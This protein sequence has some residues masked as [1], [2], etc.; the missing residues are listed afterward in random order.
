MP[1]QA[2]PGL[3]RIDF[4]TLIGIVLGAISLLVSVLAIVLFQEAR[5]TIGNEARAYGHEILLWT[6]ILGVIGWI[7]FLF[8]RTLRLSKAEQQVKELTGQNAQL[9]SS[10]LTSEAENKTLRAERNAALAIT[11]KE[12]KRR[13]DTY[14]TINYGHLKYPPFL[15]YTDGDSPDGLGVDL[16]T[17]LLNFKID[18]RAIRIHPFAHKGDW[19]TILDDLVAKK[20]DVVATPLFATFERSKLVRF[21]SPL[22]FSNVGLY[23]SKAVAEL[24]IWKHLT[25]ENLTSTIIQAG[26][27]ADP[28]RKLQLLAVKGEISRKLA[29]KYADQDSI[30]ELE[31]TVIL[32][33]LFIQIAHTQDSYHGLFCESFYAFH[34]PCVR[35]GEVVNVLPLH[36][37]LYPVCFAVRLGDYHLTN[38]L[39]IRLL[40]LTRNGGA[41]NLLG[42]KLADR[43]GLT[44]AEVKQHFVAEWPSPAEEKVKRENAYV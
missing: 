29:H 30:E 21:T 20:Y 25:V 9:K 32:S 11:S 1:E 8:Y 44:Q 27:L 42:K 35:S 43:S 26:Q 18:G 28:P 4:A 6:T 17:E 24:P 16:L 34:Q 19:S 10:N 14:S 33:D 39:N 12:S 36:R 23:L 3:R 2:T 38:L 22:F 13:W 37:F 31:S 40:E 5:N 15:D 7:F 41:L